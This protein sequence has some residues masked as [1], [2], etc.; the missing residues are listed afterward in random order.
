MSLYRTHNKYVAIYPIVTNHEKGISN[1]T[2]TRG[3][4]TTDRLSKTAVP[5]IVALPSS[6]GFFYEGQ[7]VFLTAEIYET[8]RIVL[9]LEGKGDVWLIQDSY[10]GIVE[11]R[12]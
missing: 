8:P 5:A 2:T 4:V 11:D 1:Q 3:F 10:I 12:R 7:R 6:D 9:K